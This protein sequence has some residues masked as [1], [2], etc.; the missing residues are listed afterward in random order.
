M[1]VYRILIGGSWG[2][3][4]PGANQILVHSDLRQIEVATAQLKQ[5]WEAAGRAGKP[6]LYSC[7]IFGEADFGTPFGRGLRCRTGPGR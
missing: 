2:R 1:G 6:R 7:V 3:C 5:R 4:F